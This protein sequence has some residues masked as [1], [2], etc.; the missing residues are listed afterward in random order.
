MVAD[1]L[2]HHTALATCEDSLE[3]VQASTIFITIEEAFNL[4]IMV[5]HLAYQI[6]LRHLEV[7]H[8]AHM[9][10]FSLEPKISLYLQALSSRPGKFKI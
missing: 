4:K 8:P 10:A 6:I 2:T 5:D 7:E 1:K 3:M 9:V